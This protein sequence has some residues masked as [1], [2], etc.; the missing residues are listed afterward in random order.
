MNV[1]DRIRLQHMLDATTEALSFS[2]GR[3][4]ADLDVDRML[5]LALVK[6]IEIIGEAAAKVSREGQI[7][8]PE[9]PWVDIISMRNR[10][11]HAYFDINL[12]LVWETVQQDLPFLIAEIQRILD[13]VE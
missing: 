1:P 10:L 3:T 11:I 8:C 7:E 12:D 13:T 4:R 5:L 6:D 9:L 2:E